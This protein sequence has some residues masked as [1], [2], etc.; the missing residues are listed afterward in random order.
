MEHVG[1]RIKVKFIRI[2]DVDEFIKQ[3]PKSTFNGIHKSYEI[4]DNY[5]LKQNEVIM[6]KPVHLGFAI[7]KFSKLN[8][9]EALLYITTL[10]WSS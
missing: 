7:L 5:T 1:N 2:G 9:Y 8:K 10:F 3:Q 4:C 6:D